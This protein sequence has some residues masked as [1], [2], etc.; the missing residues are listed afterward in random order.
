[1]NLIFMEECLIIEHIVAIITTPQQPATTD[2]KL[3]IRN[4]LLIKTSLTI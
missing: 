4:C 3:F 2:F 1:M